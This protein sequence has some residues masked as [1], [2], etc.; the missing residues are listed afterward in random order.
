MLKSDV[1]KEQRWFRN[2]KNSVW[3][4]E[5]NEQF[6]KPINWNDIVDDAVKAL[7]SVGLDVGALDVRVQ[8]AKDGDGNTIKNPKW[9]IIETNSAP[10]LA[11][12]GLQKYVDIIPQ[13]IS[14]KH[15]D[16]V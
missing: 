8:S 11:D 5:E 12:V 7:V 16:K 13:L 6:D 9:I 3:I 2:D 14:E 10:G 1:P 4:V 15:G